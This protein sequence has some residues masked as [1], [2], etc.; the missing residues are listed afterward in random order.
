MLLGKSRLRRRL[1]TVP[2]C[3]GQ[4]EAGPD[5]RVIRIE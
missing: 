1:T 5:R 2:A 4:A 3:H